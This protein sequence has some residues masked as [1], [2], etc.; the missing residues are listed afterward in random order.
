[1]DQRVP[2]IRII[3]EKWQK[4]FFLRD[5]EGKGGRGYYKAIETGTLYGPVDV[6]A[7]IAETPA[8]VL[9][10]KD[11]P[12]GKRAISDWLAR[13]ECTLLGAVDR[14]AMKKVMASEDQISV[15]HLLALY[16]C[17]YPDVFGN[18]ISLD[19]YYA[20]VLHDVPLF[21]N[22]I[23]FNAHLRWSGFP[24]KTYLRAAEFKS[25]C[26][27]LNSELDVEIDRILK[28]RGFQPVF[29]NRLLLL[30]DFPS[31]AR[32]L[33]FE[34]ELIE[35]P[36]DEFIFSDRPI[37]PRIISSTIS[38]GISARLG[39]RLTQVEKN[40]GARST[41]ARPASDGEVAAINAEVRQR[42]RNWVCG[43]HPDRL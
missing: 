6:D 22:Y 12:A 30:G 39:I 23:A 16:A 29:D 38:L 36:A 33:E 8:V 32:L 4:H 26:T 3:F 2:S 24:P 25:L 14:I 20:I 9:F 10:T 18:P 21:S 43:P 42:A 17:R 31:A 15:A 34:W 1:V 19:R 28:A 35:A 5:P 13:K 11:R 41:T 27:A 37:P 40:S 7:P